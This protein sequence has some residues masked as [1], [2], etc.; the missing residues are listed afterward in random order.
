MKSNKVKCK[1]LHLKTND[2]MEQYI[3][4]DLEN[5]WVEKNLEVLVDTKLNISQ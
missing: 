4:A 2:P 5:N 3:L 1:V